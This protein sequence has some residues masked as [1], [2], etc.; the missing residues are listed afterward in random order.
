MPGKKRLRWIVIGIVC[1][2]LLYVLTAPFVLDKTYKESWPKTFYAPVIAS[3]QNE[4][5]G[6]GIAQWYCYDVC[7]ME[8]MLPLEV[9][10]NK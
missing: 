2:V 6:R 9:V 4:W 1:L 10:H 8:L 7:E 5:F 3:I